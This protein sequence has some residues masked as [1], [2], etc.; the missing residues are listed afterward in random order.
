MVQIIKH[1]KQA[2]LYRVNLLKQ[3]ESES[4]MFDNSEA[5]NQKL[6][7]LY[8]HKHYLPKHQQKLLQSSISKHLK[9]SQQNIQTWLS[10]QY[11]GLKNII[12]MELSKQQVILDPKISCEA[13]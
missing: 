12:Q 9:M 13:D 11:T 4:H 2:W 8:D 7:Y 10:Q 1:W 5:S 6:Q 3:Y